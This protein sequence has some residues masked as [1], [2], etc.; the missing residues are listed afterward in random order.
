MTP[1]PRFKVAAAHVAPIYHDTAKSVDKACSIIHEAARQGVQLL[2]FPEAFIPGF[3][4]WSNVGAPTHTHRYFAELAEQAI[5][6]DGP[7]IER[8]RDAARRNGIIVSIGF[9]ESTEASSGCIWNSNIFIDSDGSLLNHHRKLVP[10]YFE[11]LVWAPGD[12]A[13]LRVRDTAIGR[14]GMLICGENTNPLAR[15]TMIAQGEQIHVSTYPPVAPMRPLA[16]S[17]GYDLEQAIRI[18]AAAHSFEGKVFNV[19]ASTFYDATL[20]KAMEPLGAEVLELMDQTPKSVSMIIDPAGNVVG[21]TLCG[22]EGLCIAEIDLSSI[23]ELK[24]LHDVSGYYNR[25]DIFRLEVNRQPLEPIHFTAG[26]DAVGAGGSGSAA[27]AAR[28]PRIA[29]APRG[30]ARGGDPRL[31]GNE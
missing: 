30:D 3:P 15:Y 14:V 18:R 26:P 31:D 5:R 1:Y 11:K 24:R 21:K 6:L 22:D 16:E 29:D 28:H 2:A 8:L 20:R 19:V 12:G 9:N 17:G 23:R 13:G 10:T 25:F 7:E 4:V 27:S